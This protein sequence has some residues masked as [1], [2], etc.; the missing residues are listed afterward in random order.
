MSYINRKIPE[1]SRSIG[2]SS[3][4]PG[5]LHVGSISGLN[6]FDP[7]C[8]QEGSPMIPQYLSHHHKGAVLKIYNIPEFFPV[9][10]VLPDKVVNGQQLFDAFGVSPSGM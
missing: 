9:S 1:S 10:N 3:G 6:M 8:L 7:Y 5:Y 4:H 2:S